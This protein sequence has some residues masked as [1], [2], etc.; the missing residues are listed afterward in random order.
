MEIHNLIDS[1]QYFVD[2]TK[3]NYYVVYE[4]FE[5]IQAIFKDNKVEENN[6]RTEE[7][8]HIFYGNDKANSLRSIYSYLLDLKKSSINDTL[9]TIQ[10]QH[11][12]I[13]K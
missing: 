13:F 7:I 4:K 6:R 11:K 9:K 1:K 2:Q 8:I 12:E 3:M 10:E 5:N